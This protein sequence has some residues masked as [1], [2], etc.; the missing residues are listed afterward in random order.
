MDSNARHFTEA[1]LLALL[2]QKEVSPEDIRKRRG[3]DFAGKD[4]FR[5]GETKY[6][7]LCRLH[8]A[9]AYV[10]VGELENA[11]F[12]FDKAAKDARDIGFNRIYLK[13]AS[14][15]YELHRSLGHKEDIPYAQKRVRDATE[16]IHATRK[17]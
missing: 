13:A 7:L 3:L 9:R 2:D 15:G 10:E 17:S 16:R 1:D 11:A 8:A 12:S 6:A 4:A 14:K 5:W